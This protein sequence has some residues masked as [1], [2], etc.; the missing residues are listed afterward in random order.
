MGY[1]V[2]WREVEREA[3][4]G[5][6]MAQED[7]L[8]EA[9]LGGAPRVDGDLPPILATRPEQLWWGCTRTVKTADRQHP[10]HI[11]NHDGQGEEQ[12]PEKPPSRI[13]AISMAA[14]KPCYG[15]FSPP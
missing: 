13:H 5:Q 3:V 1:G 14:I 8:L 7:G 10:D 2:R 6:P 15:P 12:P 11:S 9:P 4:G